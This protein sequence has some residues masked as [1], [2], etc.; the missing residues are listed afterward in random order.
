MEI[1]DVLMADGI[2]DVERHV[3]VKRSSSKSQ[4]DERNKIYGE[5]V[6]ILKMI[7]FIIEAFFNKKIYW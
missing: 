7:L 2:T 4:H 5:I 6:F 3:E 1:K